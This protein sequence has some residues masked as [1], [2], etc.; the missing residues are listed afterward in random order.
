MMSRQNG[1]AAP[2]KA[3]RG[4]CQRPATSRHG[5]HGGFSQPTIGR[6][7]RTA[8]S[9]NVITERLTKRAEINDGG[10]GF[11]GE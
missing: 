2:P 1:H 11:G 9:H 7:T 4:P 5:S 3:R 10:V 6:G 8:Q